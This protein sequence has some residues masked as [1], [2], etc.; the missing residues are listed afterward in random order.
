MTMTAA[1]S[2]HIDNG[3]QTAED[4]GTMTIALSVSDPS[5]RATSHGIDALNENTVTKADVFIYANPAGAATCSLRDLPVSGAGVVEATVPGTAVAAVTAAGGAATV[6]VLANTPSGTTIPM[7]PTAGELRSTRLSSPVTS[8]QPQESFPMYGEGNATLSAGTLSGSVTLERIPAKIEIAITEITSPDGVWQPDPAGTRATL[9]NTVSAGSVSEPSGLKTDRSNTTR[10]PFTSDG[11]AYTHTLPFYSYPSDWSAAAELAMRIVLSVP[12]SDD[13]G[14]TWRQCYYQVPVSDA[15]MRVGRNEHH[16]I[17]LSISILGSFEEE[18]PTEIRPSF[19]IQSWSAEP[20]SASIADIRYLV[21]ETN[22]VELENTPSAE[23]TY[24]SSHPVIL[25]NKTL[26]QTDLKNNVETVVP[27]SNYT[28]GLVSG[29]LVFSHELN[30]DGDAESDFAPY[31]LTAVLAHEDN[32]IYSQTIT[33]TQYPAISVVA[34]PN[35]GANVSGS[36]GYAYVN[37]GNGGSYGGN[38]SAGGTT[39]NYNMYVLSVTALQ[40]TSGYVIGDPRTKEIDNL[41]TTSWGRPSYTWSSNT[42]DLNGNR[43]R[44][45]YYHPTETGERTVDMLAPKFRV[46][47]SYG[48]STKISYENAERRCATYQEDGYPAGRWRIPTAAE[49]RFIIDMSEKGV[50]PELFT[51]KYGGN[52]YWCANGSITGDGNDDMVFTEDDY[53][54]TH[55]VRCVYDEWFWGDFQISPRTNFRWG[56]MDY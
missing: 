50:I 22:S 24:N 25:K 55:S 47:S 36:K 2:C 21:V 8:S 33:I 51:I 34:S 14:Q 12:W 54:G 32:D 52:G 6:R 49:I 4:G 40:P 10:Y 28:C 18:E 26:K 56:D 13:G 29:R 23:V 27:E 42:Y 41:P 45:S 43:R 19:V 17:S 7:N 53:S 39:S 5:T 35:S 44:L 1:L 3:L 46:A 38:P 48:A 11:T 16:K 37:N 30:N 31:T 20:N 9:L 15:S